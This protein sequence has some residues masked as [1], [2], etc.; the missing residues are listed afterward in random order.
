MFGRIEKQRMRDLGIGEGL[1][2]PQFVR[3]VPADGGW[4]AVNRLG[5]MLMRDPVCG[6]LQNDAALCWGCFVLPDC[7]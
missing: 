6:H 5:D 1:G 3:I 4:R 7:H 2:L